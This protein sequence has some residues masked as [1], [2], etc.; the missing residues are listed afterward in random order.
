MPK[1]LAGQTPPGSPPAKSLIGKAFEFVASLAGGEPGLRSGAQK[2][3]ASA[4]PKRHKAGKNTESQLK[5]VEGF[6]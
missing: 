6:E 4:K 3:K 1:H 5:K 2:P